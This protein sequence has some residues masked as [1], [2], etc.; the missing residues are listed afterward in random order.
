MNA[1]GA[2]LS[3]FREVMLNNDPQ[4]GLGSFSQGY[5]AWDLW[6]SRVTRY[7]L[8][9]GLYQ[10]NAY[11]ELLHSWSAR[12]KTTYGMYKH[13]RH[14][15]NPV[16]RL[17]EFWSGRL[18]G[19]MLDRKAG[20]GESE[21]SALPIVTDNEALRPAIA[22]LWADSRWQVEKEVY[23]R[24]GAV[25]ADVGLKVCDD[26]AKGQVR[27]EKVHPGHLKWVDFDEHGNV[28]SYIIQ[29]WMWDPRRENIAD[30]DAM[31]D[32]RSMQYPVRF[33]EKAY[34]DGEYV[35]YETLLDGEPFAWNGATGQWK[36]KYG[37]IPLVVAHHV[38]TG[39]KWAENCF[40]AGL[41]LFT[42]VDDQASCV[43]DGNR[44]E[45]NAPHLITGIKGFSEL[46]QGYA[47]RSK[48]TPQQN[49]SDPEPMRAQLGSL[50]SPNAES[51]VYPLF[52]NRDIPG[53]VLHIDGLMGNIEKN[54]PE[55]LADTGNLG[56]TVTAEAIRNARQR[57][58]SKVQARRV[59]YDDALV[60][61]QQMAIS[62]GGFRGYKGYQGFDLDGYE[63]GLLDHQIGQR[64]VFE[65]DPLDSIN[66]DQAFWTAAATAGQAGVPLEIYLERNGWS[67]AEIL[68]LS[69]AKDRED[70]RA[71]ERQAAM[72]AAGPK[73]I[74]PQAPSGKASRP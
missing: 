15:Y 41:S 16:Y 4:K 60:R 64:A 47:D 22:K 36:V 23:T 31:M 65:V 53:I 69:A 55:L 3:A 74:G 56:G 44:K 62:I 37:F 14:L 17:G 11:R 13:I 40:H 72:T 34:R 29:K 20:D 24:W 63:A 57:A 50:S 39:T 46:S 21:P 71:I 70:S 8:Y 35:V 66:E 2:A 61:A 1:T 25:L 28:K 43:G 19:G 9:W 42:E 48:R 26:T 45:L 32:P 58:S 10:N 51:R 12:Y 68:S 49:G 38:P 54:Y 7:D 59:G 67:A 73:P 30:V 33:T 18:M 5:D 52:G 6:Q 27:L